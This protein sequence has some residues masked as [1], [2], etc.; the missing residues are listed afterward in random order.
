MKRNP[1]FAPQTGFKAEKFRGVNYGLE[2]DVT[3]R[4]NWVEQGLY[5]TKAEAEKQGRA[6]KKK[7]GMRYHVKATRDTRNPITDRAK[8]YRAQKNRPPGRKLCNFC[9]SR[10][11]IDIDHVTGNESE[12]DAENL[13]YLCR[14]CNTMKGITQARNRIGTR[15]RQYNPGRASFERFKHAAAVL[16]G[17]APGS[18]AEATATIRATPPQ[19]RAEYAERLAKQNPCVSEAQ[20]RKFFAMHSRGEITDKQLRECIHGD[21]RNPAPTFP[22]YAHG[23]AIHR[24]GA[25]DEGGAIIH[26]TPPALRRKYAQQIADVKRER[27]GEVPF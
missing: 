2:I 24:R 1:L 8:R 16:I 12:G 18:A 20:R 27:R 7:E 6:I 11:N 26:A 14:T 4:G 19:T 25:H 21:A 15:T 10:R 13:I 5:S 3:G 23:V 17:I 9:A 22:Q